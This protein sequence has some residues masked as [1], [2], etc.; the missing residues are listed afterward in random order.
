MTT[1]L[2]LQR[3]NGDRQATLP[4]QPNAWDLVK[5]V[6]EAMKENMD[7]DDGGGLGWQ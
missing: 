2:Y 4:A 5:A 6:E 3:V 7:S 1:L